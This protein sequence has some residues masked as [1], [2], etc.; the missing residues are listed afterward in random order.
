M[1]C[2]VVFFIM[3]IF[4]RADE[5]DFSHAEEGGHW[6]SHELHRDAVRVLEDLLEF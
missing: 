2:W 4:P 5:G 3:A 1:K 6:C